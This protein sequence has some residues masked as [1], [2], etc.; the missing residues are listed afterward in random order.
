MKTLFI[1]ARY[2]G[3][4]RLAEPELKKLPK[5]IG[6]ATTVQF[7]N[8]LKLVSARLKQLNKIP[9]LSKVGKHCEYPCQILGCDISGAEKIKNQVDCF[10]Y[11]GTGE[12][13]PLA[14]AV[15]TKKPVFVLNPFSGKISEISKEE[16]D[17]Y[18]KKRQIRIYQVQRANKIAILVSTKP[19]QCSLVE[20]EQLKDKLEKEGKQVYLFISD[21]ISPNETLNF[22]EIEAYVNTACPRIVEDDFKKPIVN[23]GDLKA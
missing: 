10:L 16:I 5:K 12:F 13:H 4:I 3:K 15:E 7:L 14:L 6:L 17:K 1:E 2:Q 18:L 9:I 20:A 19:G 21:T 8:Q 23:I 22:P 11:L